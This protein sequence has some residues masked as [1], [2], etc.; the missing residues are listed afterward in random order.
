M[1]SRSRV[2]YQENLEKKFDVNTSDLG[3]CADS[4]TLGSACLPAT[5]TA[6]EVCVAEVTQRALLMKR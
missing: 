6:R 3:V 4:R 5:G 1:P 2:N